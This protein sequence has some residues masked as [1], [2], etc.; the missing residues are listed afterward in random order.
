[1]MPVLYGFRVVGHRAGKRKLVDW[2]A[3]LTGYAECDARAELEREAFLSLFTFGSDFADL[4]RRQGSEKG[5][6]GPCGASW[7]Y[8]DIDRPGN[9]A[10]ALRDTRRLAGA[11]LDRYRSLDDDDL[12]IFLSGGKGLH[13]GIPTYWQPEPSRNFNSV[14]KVF[15]LEHAKAAK[16]EVDGSIYSKTRLF[17]APNS[18]HPKTGLF[19]RR[20][21]LEELTF[22]RPEAV[23]EM[24]RQPEPFSIP[25]GPGFCPKATDDWSSA[26]RAVEHQTER[27]SGPREG[28]SQLRTEAGSEPRDGKGRLSAFL[29]RFIRDG[30]LDTDRRAVSTFRAAAQ[31]AEF[32]EAHGFDALAHALLR[33]AALDSGLPPSEVKRQIDCGLAHGRRQRERSEHD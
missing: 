4:L 10:L 14:A 32:H 8:W 19:K 27:R 29:T 22:L 18:R 20:L 5:F 16:L 28:T 11:I 25:R 17:R 3:A 13:L 30:E 7:L 15:A 2:Q 6:S 26:R 33:E 9:L 24:A 21:S 1:M 31:L 12:L 23:L